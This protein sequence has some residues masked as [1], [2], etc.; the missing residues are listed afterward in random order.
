M[1]SIGISIPTY[2]DEKTIEKLIKES[3]NVL[4]K[5]TNNYEIVIID[6]GS[7][8]GTYEILEKIKNDNYRIRI[9]RHNINKG[10]GQTIKEVFTFPKTEWI[11]FLPGDGQV[12][13]YELYKLLPFIENADFILG[14]R[15]NRQDGI[16]RKLCSLCYNIF[17]SI[18]ANKCV[19]DVNSIALFKR[20]I[21][22]NINIKSNSAF[23][24]A[25]IFLKLLKKGYKICEVKIKHRARIFG[26]SGAVRF[27]VIF[28]TF[29]DILFYILGRLK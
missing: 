17:I 26:R 4:S 1:K 7:V 29:K 24:Y 22:N 13:P 28:S 12:S 15:K 23:V 18:L 20:E 11:L 5:F 8:D 10:F 25:E 21:V 6:D 9:F 16:L 27:K 19:Y 14:V 2:N 3:E